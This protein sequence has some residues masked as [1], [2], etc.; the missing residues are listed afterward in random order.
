MA[1]NSVRSLHL[2]C[3]SGIAGNIFASTLAA[4]LGDASFLKWIPTALR[5]PD[6]FN[7]VF[8]GY[9][10]DGKWMD[11]FDGAHVGGPVT[12]M[13][14]LAQAALGDSATGSVAA[15]ILER[16]WEH[17][18][19]RVVYNEEWC[20]TLFDCCAAA[21]GL[22]ALGWPDVYVHGP[23]PGNRAWHPLARRILDDWDVY[24]TDVDLEIVTPT[25]AAILSTVAHQVPLDSEPCTSLPATVELSGNFVRKL[26][27]PAQRSWLS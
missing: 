16:R 8:D 11:P 24:E 19:Q 14:P 9:V 5:L 2:E 21:V 17:D 4:H 3:P 12:A 6:S 13:A 7:L 22:E 23:L 25:G 26:N 15:A 27:L 1:A 10:W 20:D 18:T